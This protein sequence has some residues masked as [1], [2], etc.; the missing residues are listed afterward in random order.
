MN[1]IESTLFERQVAAL[2]NTEPARCLG[3]RA[4]WVRRRSSRQFTAQSNPDVVIWEHY[5]HHTHHKVAVECKHTRSPNQRPSVADHIEQLVPQCEGER[6]L[7][8]LMVTSATVQPQDHMACGI[9]L[10]RRCVEYDPRAE[11]GRYKLG[12]LTLHESALIRDIALQLAKARGSL[13]RDDSGRIIPENS[14]FWQFMPAER[15]AQHYEN[16]VAGVTDPRVAFKHQYIVESVREF[17]GVG[18][19]GT[20]YTTFLR[21]NSLLHGRAAEDPSW[22]SNKFWHKEFGLVARFFAYLEDSRQEC[23]DDRCRC[24]RCK[25]VRHALCEL[26]NL[27]LHH[28]APPGTVRYAL[29]CMRRLPLHWMFSDIDAD[30]FVDVIVSRFSD[31]QASLLVERDAVWPFVWRLGYR[32]MTERYAHLRGEHRTEILEDQFQ[33]SQGYEHSLALDL[34]RMWRENRHI[35]HREAICMAGYSDSKAMIKSPRVLLTYDSGL[36]S[37]RNADNR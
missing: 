22:R 15:T 32:R 25:L 24:K 16:V 36:S 27:A 17:I 6:A 33:A 8:S 21:L 1:H 11:H 12:Q 35:S 14:P 31:P 5:G 9:L 28:D 7:F 20:A 30:A 10:L 2:F 4:E 3:L 29:L 18:A 13:F 19:D 37:F 26:R 23:C 34:R